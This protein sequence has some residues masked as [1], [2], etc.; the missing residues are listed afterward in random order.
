MTAPAAG[1]LIERV[2]SGSDP[3]LRRHAARGL[4]PLPPG[5]LLP[6]QV[7]LARGDDPE[8]AAAARASLLAADP[9]VVAEHLAREAPPEVQAWFAAASSDPRV[10]EALVRRR[11]VP[12]AVLLDLAP[13]LPAALQELLVH[14]QDALV[15]EPAIADALEA[16]PALSAYVRRRLGEYREHLLRPAGEP[17]PAPAPE[18]VEEARDEASDD[19]LARALAE[20]ARQP[21]AGELEPE[22]KLTEAQIRYLPVPVRMRLSRG[23]PRTLRAILLRDPNPLVACSVLHNNTFSDEE[24]ERIAKNRNVDEEVLSEIGRH[25]EWSRKY[26]VLLA[27]VQNAKTPLSLALSLVP[28]VAVRDLRRLSLDRNVPDAVRSRARRLYTIKRK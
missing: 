14:R 15:D 26:R 6:L 10:V 4:L 11:D 2:R 1:S 12:R 5:E 7:E 23:A 21:A 27:L 28:R 3:E 8:L 20:A 16:N 22:T 9:R 17:V 13:R 19:S 18:P 25:R 24:I